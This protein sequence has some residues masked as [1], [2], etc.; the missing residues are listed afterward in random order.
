MS[1]NSDPIELQGW[2]RKDGDVVENGN[3]KIERKI[4]ESFSRM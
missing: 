3:G 4:G 1:N 2:E